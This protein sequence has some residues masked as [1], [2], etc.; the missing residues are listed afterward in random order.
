MLQSWE[1]M[2][3]LQHEFD[4]TGFYLSAH[5]LDEYRTLFPTRLQRLKRSAHCR[6]P[7]ESAD[8]TAVK[9]AGTVLSRQERTSKR[10]NRFAFIAVSDSSGQSEITLCSQKCWRTARTLLD[11]PGKPLL[12]TCEAAMDGEDVRL[13]AQTVEQLDAAVG[14]TGNG[15]NIFIEACEA[16]PRIRSVLQREPS[17]RGEVRILFDMD[18]THEVQDVAGQ[19][20]R[21]HAGRADGTEGNEAISWMCRRYRLPGRA[22]FPRAS[23]GPEH[24]G[25]QRGADHHR[26]YRRP[27]WCVATKATSMSSDSAIRFISANPPGV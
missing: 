8:A 25:Q 14:K 1:P 9:I 22:L 21:R 6:M 15:L 24:A 7:R 23:D 10:G 27:V 11:V 13:T 20:F 18:S 19:P 5:P 26:R 16:L 2:E 4:A 12:F 3:R 17:G